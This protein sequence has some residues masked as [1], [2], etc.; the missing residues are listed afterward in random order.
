MKKIIVL[1]LST[2]IFSNINAQKIIKWCRVG[3][4]YFIPT[5]SASQKDGLL[6]VSNLIDPNGVIIIPVVVH[7]VRHS[8]VAAE[9][10]SDADVAIMIA[11]VNEDWTKQNADIS[12]V[13]PVWQGLTADMKIQLKLA[14]IK[15]DG[16]P[17]NGIV[18]VVTTNSGTFCGNIGGSTPYCGDVKLT[19]QGGSDAWPTDTYLNIWICER[20]EIGGEAMFPWERFGSPIIVS[21]ISHLSS[22]FD[23][24]V[25]DYRTVGTGLSVSHN[26]NRVATHELGHWLGLWHTYQGGCG[27]IGD[28]VAD[29][30]PQS[31]IVTDCPAF[32]YTLDNCSPGSPG[33]MFMNIMNQTPDD[34]KL[35]FTTGQKDRARSYFSQTGPIDTRYPFIKNYFSIKHFATNPINV[36]NNTITIN[37]Q[38]PACLNATYSFSGATVTEIS[39]TNQQLVLSVPCNTNG[40]LRVTATAGNY[41]DTYVFDFVNNTN[42]NTQWPKVYEGDYQA[43]DIVKGNIGYVFTGFMFANSY[44]PIN[45]FGALPNSGNHV[46]QY[47]INNGYTTWCGPSD[48]LPQFALS[49]GTMQIHRY[50]LPITTQY[51]NSLN[52][53]SVSPP[54]FLPTDELIEAEINSNTFITRSYIGNQVALHI[55]KSNNTNAV[56]IMPQGWGFTKSFY[57]PISRNLLV[58]S[59]SQTGSTTLYFYH[60]NGTA[61]QLINTYTNIWQQVLQMNS[62]D[63]VFLLINGQIYTYNFTTNNLA[64]F[65]IGSFNNN[66]IYYFI[67]MNKN[68][69]DKFLVFSQNSGY[70]YSINSVLSTYK[71]IPYSPSNFVGSFLYN[72]D[73]VFIHG[74]TENN[75]TV[76]IGN[77]I[78]PTINALS[79]FFTKFNL[80]NDFTQ[81]AVLSNDPPKNQVNEIPIIN[82]SVTPNPAINY[83]QLN[84]AKPK[85]RKLLT[86]YTVTVSS[87]EG[88][89]LVKQ[90]IYTTTPNINIQGLG[91]G[92]YFVTLADGENNHCTHSFIKK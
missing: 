9:N 56:T 16:S 36:V 30:Q 91:T 68:V 64:I 61:L 53:S 86:E 39:R 90:K 81:L 52:G 83:I 55:R 46:F 38:N 41:I 12:L 77:Q 44:A 47:N 7:I 92:V 37:M 82:F 20:E 59:F 70:I 18:R 65:N 25:L 50:T 74:T 48:F 3:D 45:H 69:D 73:D 88:L 17:T 58:S 33:I 67:P 15:P 6:D 26:K 8:N 23:G 28:E 71:K 13:P 79:L 19:S 57:N 63:N 32:P 60:Y 51:I 1:L 54:N 2:F 49:N 27:I 87:K 5:N 29:T 75:G 22:E 21:G 4:N 66:G 31:T 80:S 89:V 40:T 10:I 24:F 78:M 62:N 43:F 14:C 76:Y 85:L 35:F 84:I 34:C 11:R 42:C 72:N